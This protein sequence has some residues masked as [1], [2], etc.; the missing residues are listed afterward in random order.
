MKRQS[1]IHQV[2]RSSF[3]AKECFSEQ[4]IQVKLDYIH[5]NPVQPGWNLVEDFT[6]YSHSSAD[7]YENRGVKKFITHYKEFF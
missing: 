7:F 3:D 6:F 5:H 1:E 2:F 4:M